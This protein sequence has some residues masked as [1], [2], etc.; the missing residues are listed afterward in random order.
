MD[1]YLN[2]PGMTGKKIVEEITGRNILKHLGTV[3]TDLEARNHPP[4][5]GRR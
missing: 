3:K 5:N 4:L 1:R 2:T